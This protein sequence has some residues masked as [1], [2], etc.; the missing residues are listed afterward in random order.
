MHLRKT[1]TANGRI[2]LTIV[3][4]YYDKETKK[5]RSKSIEPLGY[6]DV[7][8]KK[9]DD[10]IA[11]AQKRVDELKAQKNA[12]QAPISFT[13]YHTDHLCT[14]DTHLRKNFGYADIF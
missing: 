10:P 3:D 1:K 9:Y 12:K 6:L 14:D 5:S 13:F 7:L 8:A 2:Y 4:S 11:Y